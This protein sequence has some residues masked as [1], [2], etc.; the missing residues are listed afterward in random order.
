MDFD[1]LCL[2]YQGVWDN[3]WSRCSPGHHITHLAVRGMKD[4]GTNIDD[5]GATNVKVVCSDNQTVQGKGGTD[6][7]WTNLVQCPSHMRI[8][9]LRAKIQQYQ[10]NQDNTA[11]NRIQLYCCPQALE[12]SQRIFISLLAVY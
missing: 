2:Y 9:G 6:G 5:Y 7:E 4:Y 1:S 11:L 8:C 3:S 12:G 10:T